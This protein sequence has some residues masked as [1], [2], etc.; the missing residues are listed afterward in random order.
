MGKTLG[1]DLRENL[2]GE[3]RDD[4]VS[5]A[6]YSVDASIYEVQ[7]LAIALP[8]NHAELLRAIEI[9]RHHNVSI[10]PRGAATGITGGCLGQGLVIDTSKYLRD[11]HEVNFDAEYAICD[12]GVV[13]SQLN[14]VLAPKDYR[15]GP[16]T[17]TGNRATLGGMLANNSAGA[18]SLRYG[19][20]SDHIQEVEVALYS[21][22]I[23]RF[24]E[25]SDSQLQDKLQLVGCEGDIYR[26]VCRIKTEY[27]ADIA[28]R[29]PKIPRRASGYNL[30]A[31]LHPG[32]LNIAKLIAGSEGTLGFITQ[33]RVRISR[34]PQISGLCLIHSPTLHDALSLVASLLQHHPLSLE[35]VDS[36]II[37]AGR[38]APLT[39]HRVGWIEGQPGAILIV[40]FDAPTASAL[41]DKLNKL[42]AAVSGDKRAYAVK[43]LTEASEMANVW[44]VRE[45]GVGLLLS[46][47]SYS[48][49]IAFIEDFSVGPDVLAPFM[50]EFLQLLSRHGKEAGV[51]GHV[52]AGCMHV[53]PYINLRNPADLKTMRQIM[54]ETSDLLLRY[55]GSLSGE[56]GDGLV[57][58]WLNEKMFGPRLYQAFRELKHVFDPLGNMNPGKIVA[59]QG[60][61]EHLRTDPTVV[62]PAITTAYDFSRQGGFHLAVDMCNGNGLCRK[63]EG[64]MC[65]SFQAFGD[66]MH[67]T[68]ARA[69]SLREII[70]GRF[71]LDALQ[72][73]ELYA[74]LEYCLE[75]KGCKTE[76]PSQVDMA[77]M[78]AEFLYHYQQKRGYSLRSRLFAHLAS[79]N[80]FTAPMATVFNAINNSWV[81]KQLL[82]SIGI[83]A[84]RSLP[85][86]A[87]QRFSRWLSTQPPSSGNKGKVV[88]LLD[89]FTEFHNPEIGR[90]ALAVL[91]ALGYQVIVPP[92]QCCGRP[93]ISKGFL[94]Q[95][96]EAAKRV[97]SLL[98][99]Y[100]KQGLPILGLEPSCLFTL[101]D[102]YPDLLPSD[103]ARLLAQASTPI[104]AFLAEALQDNP[105][106][107][108]TR[109]PNTT[110][111]FHTHCH[112]KALA[113]SAATKTVLKN[114]PGVTV[115]EID[116]GCCGMA[117]SFG[118]EQEH[119][120][121]SMA[122]GESR[123]FP[124]V[125]ASTH[126]TLIVADGFS[127]RSQIHH[128]TQRNAL[129]LV[130]LL[131]S[132]Q[133]YDNARV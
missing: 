40:E 38:A 115:T 19:K 107:W 132:Y 127:C 85:L 122:I 97:I 9:A 8:K 93:L 128:G 108:I 133:Q 11:I 1:Q 130:Q 45:T 55:H 22:E 50:D 67:S 110:V 68:R 89:T 6:V 99:P 112:Q 84:E 120:A 104:D 46:K 34:R 5:R 70:N 25:V 100:A 101:K 48:R 123:L 20:M 10:I 42:I 12:P 113:G 90:D 76:C 66:E 28:E 102:E 124:A 87:P 103:E 77:K 47:R 63:R 74:V 111:L 82:K 30:D 44:A 26:E 61:Q 2:E 121:M 88:L 57:R 91:Q 18:R 73:D 64:L 23:I 37:A 4:V 72:S 51:Y 71:P 131:A 94:D 53:R 17:S 75:C 95:A 117:G 24:H 35:M 49:A 59:R 83:A 15:L 92:W 114:L 129:H 33:M 52:G 16:D 118:Y 7:P 65:P 32:P 41:Q 98:L 60:L 54:E 14:A 109:E 58:S 3:V 125:R 119:Y 81:G 43:S 56:H 13:Q 21:G 79:I 31:L 69:Q 116:S 78:K 86:L 126:D 105:P 62:Q 80:T 106:Q 36:H 96:K 27:A 29:F 39:A